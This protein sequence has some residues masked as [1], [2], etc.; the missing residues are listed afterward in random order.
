MLLG[1]D[2]NVRHHPMMMIGDRIKSARRRLKLTQERLADMV[3]VE[4]PTVSGWESDPEPRPARS[5]LPALAKA[6]KVT[7]AYLEFGG[8]AGE[9][10]RD[11]D[12]GG[13]IDDARGAP[14]VDEAL[15]TEILKMTMQSLVKPY[16]VD[17]PERKYEDAAA[18]AANSYRQHARLRKSDA[19]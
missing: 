12:D 7:P 6:L 11:W 8:G 9:G 19:A 15:L 1:S 18:T 2:I 4:Q 16:G 17:I 10:G 3:G 13:A 14:P 5:I